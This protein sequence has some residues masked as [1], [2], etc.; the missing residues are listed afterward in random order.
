MQFHYNQ[1]NSYSSLKYSLDNISPAGLLRHKYKEKLKQLIKRQQV[2]GAERLLGYPYNIIE[3]LVRLPMVQEKKLIK[4]P[5]CDFEFQQ[6]V[7][8][9]TTVKLECPRCHHK[10]AKNFPGPLDQLIHQFSK[11]S[12]TVK[13]IFLLIFLVS[14]SIIIYKIASTTKQKSYPS[15]KSYDKKRVAPK[16][17]KV[18]QTESFKFDENNNHSDY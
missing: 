16:V 3:K 10:Y 1:K 18:E 7:E 12:G 14:C 6:I 17:R 11:L 5:Q 4:C 2:F 9:G 13:A 8:I 15:Y